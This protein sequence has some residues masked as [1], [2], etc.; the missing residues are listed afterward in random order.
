MT[1]GSLQLPVS[2][3]IGM[4]A[5]LA[6]LIS[7]ARHQRGPFTAIDAS[8]VVM[9]MVI[10]TAVVMPVV[11]T[12]SE[13]ARLTALRQNLHTLRSRIEQYKAEHGGQPPL[14]F[15]G[16]FP[17]LTQATNEAGV[18]GPRGKDYPLG[19]YLPD[20][21][22]VNPCT[23]SNVVQPTDTFPPIASAG[24]GW[25]YHQ[26]TGQIAADQLPKDATTDPH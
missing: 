26:A 10:V 14:L 4:M 15:Q 12:A 7:Y 17:Q 19:P 18:P 3:L 22:P 23:G 16:G 1:V 2:I 9:I 8:I 6:Y 20:G 25:L 24:G 13:N 21:V 5:A 11:N